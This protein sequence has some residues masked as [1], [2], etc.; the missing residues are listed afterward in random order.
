VLGDATYGRRTQN[1]PPRMA[2]HATRLAF[3][4][5]RTGQ[6][7]DFECPWPADLA[8]WLEGLRAT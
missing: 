4:H 5:P 6:A 1:D 2:L 3:A 8:S 7:L